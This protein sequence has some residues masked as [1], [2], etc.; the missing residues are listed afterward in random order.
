MIQKYQFYMTLPYFNCIYLAQ[1]IKK[2][3]LPLLKLF[4]Q[5]NKLGLVRFYYYLYLLQLTNRA[6]YI[7]FPEHRYHVHIEKS[8]LQNI[9]LSVWVQVKWTSQFVSEMYN[10]FFFSLLYVYALRGTAKTDGVEC[11]LNKWFNRCH[12]GKK[13]YLRF[14]F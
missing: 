2:G 9:I 12:S 4:D 3:W 10:I 1:Y 11:T 7:L 6:P 14:S 13:G 8:F 5:V